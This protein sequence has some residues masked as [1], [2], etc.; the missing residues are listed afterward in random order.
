MTI[1]TEEIYG[2]DGLD[3]ER[4]MQGMADRTANAAQTRPLHLRIPRPAFEAV[5]ALAHRQ[6]ITVDALASQML[7]EAM[8]D[9]GIWT[10]SACGDVLGRGTPRSYADHDVTSPLCPGCADVGVVEHP[11]GAV[12]RCECQGEGEGIVLINADLCPEVDAFL[13]RLASRWI[14]PSE[15][16]Q[17]FGMSGPVIVHEHDGEAD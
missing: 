15:A 3:P 8:E 16:R 10:C 14:T 7:V 12:E 2:T 6:K 9:E 1:D 5:E 4:M 17:E 13:D 11:D